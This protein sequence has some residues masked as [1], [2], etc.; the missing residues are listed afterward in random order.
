MQGTSYPNAEAA[1]QIQIAKIWNDL[2]S[3]QSQVHQQNM[4][5]FPGSMNHGVDNF[6][7][8]PSNS[9][10]SRPNRKGLKERLR[11][12]RRSARTQSF[13]ASE[14]EESNS[15]EHK[16][17]LSGDDSHAERSRALVV[18]SEV[19]LLA[20]MQE[21][22]RMSQD[23]LFEHMDRL[24]KREVE[25]VEREFQ[26]DQNLRDERHRA[27]QASLRLTEVEGH[28]QAAQFEISRLEMDRQSESLRA[29]QAEQKLQELQQKLLDAEIVGHALS[30]QNEKLKE[31]LREAQTESGT[32]IARCN[33]LTTKLRKAD[34]ESGSLIAHKQKLEA[35][36]R[37]AEIESGTLFARYWQLQEEKSQMQ[38]WF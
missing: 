24:R 34:I 16:V 31:S 8:F 19:T 1:C 5:S 21:S 4:H 33:K 25:L 15:D 3:L 18:S 12:K 26:L 35:K 28:L 11:N 30:E 10:R 7:I 13:T 17:W 27:D 2:L 20:S 29:Q 32:F 37:N 36:L 6:E 14:C 9:R 22:L 23:K 38:E